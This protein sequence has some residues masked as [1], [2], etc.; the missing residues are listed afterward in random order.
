MCADIVWSEA[1]RL[2]A[3]PYD[4]FPRSVAVAGE[5]GYVKRPS[6]IRK[7]MRVASAI[8]RLAPEPSVHGQVTGAVLLRYTM[9]S[10]NIGAIPGYS[11]EKD[12]DVLLRKHTRPYY[13]DIES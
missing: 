1:K 10:A 11:E 6:G 5:Y 2:V 12:V 9:N 3:V 4:R 7:R 8:S 13:R